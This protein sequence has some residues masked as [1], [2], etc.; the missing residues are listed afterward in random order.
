MIERKRR[1]TVFVLVVL[2]VV[3]A[4]GAY[5]WSEY[6]RSR[7]AQT[8][9]SD[10]D[11]AP[12]DAPITGE[13]IVFR[14]TA[15][16]DLYG[17]VAAVAA[18]DPG[19]P[20]SV[21]PVACDR[22]DTTGDQSVCLRTDR[23][24]VTTF[25]A[26]LLDADWQVIQTWPLPG[27]PSRTRLSPDGSLI[28][29]TS[30]VTGHS[31]ATTG[32]STETVIHS[33]GGDDY[34]NIEEFTLLENGAE[35]A[36]VDR[37][38][39]GVTFVDDTTFYATTQS[40]ALGHTWLVEGDLEARTLSVVRDGVECPSLS[41]DGSRIA[42]KKDV[43]DGSGVHWSIAV[44]DL[45]SGEETVL[46]EERNVDDQVEWLDDDTLLYGLPRDDE[47]GVSDVWAVPAAGGAPKVLI[48]EAWS[49][50]VVRS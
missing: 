36:P 19:G 6:S 50:A 8:T 20:R 4:A 30:F 7:D 32:F 22:I 28:A 14:S 5:G 24:I 29:T 17:R 11:L 10:V 9:A 42:F 16:G 44:L 2:V 18:D 3:V 21:A 31:Y 25:E 40:R 38:M 47:P 34:G 43:D 12:A 27:I 41:P 33:A 23:G 35:I 26:Q 37:N 15:P 39:W 49:P 46:D 13:R 1:V 48:P 45:A